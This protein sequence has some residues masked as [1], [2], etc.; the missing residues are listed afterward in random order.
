MSA[1]GRFFPGL[2]FVRRAGPGGGREASANP[3][4]TFSCAKTRLAAGCSG[5]NFSMHWPKSSELL[6]LLMAPES[7]DSDQALN[8]TPERLP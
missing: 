6:V 2:L 4:T 5:I 7:H 1:D 8:T 3:R